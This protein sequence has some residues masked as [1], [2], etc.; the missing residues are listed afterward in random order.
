[1]KHPLP[2]ILLFL[3]S[4]TPC[5]AIT[6]AQL[7]RLIP[8]LIE[9]ESGGVVDAVGDSG[10]AVGVLQ[11][12]KAYLADGNRFAGTNYTHAEMFDPDKSI[13]IVRAYLLH[14]ARD[15]DIEAA[16]R[17]HNGGPN[18]WKKETTLPYWRKVKKELEK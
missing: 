18:G 3:H 6:P 13:E 9:V 14:Y 1:M 11:I 7:D 8:A 2:L 16:A 10:R 12:H 5:P 15:K 4:C 17:I